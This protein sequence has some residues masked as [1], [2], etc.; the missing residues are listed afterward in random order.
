MRDSSS[1]IIELIRSIP[2]GKVAGYGQI[3]AMAGLPGGARLVARILHSSTLKHDLPWH[4]VLRSSGEIALAPEA[5]GREQAEMLKAEGVSFQ[6][7]WRV[8][9]KRC[10]WN[11]QVESTPIEK[12]PRIGGSL[13]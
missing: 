10:G 7:Q 9:L 6:S 3:A 11:P 5:G 2:P 12:S 4:R 8:D 1:L 13:Y